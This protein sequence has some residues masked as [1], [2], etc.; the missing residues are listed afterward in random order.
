M[1]NIG[2][3]A[4]HYREPYIGMPIAL[5][6]CDCMPDNTIDTTPTPGRPGT[7]PGMM[8]GTRPGTTPGGGQMDCLS[9][10]PIAMAYVPMQ[11]WE[12]PY[13]PAE[14]LENGTIFPSLNLPFLGGSR[15]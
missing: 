10:L 13:E 2:R 12:T 1:N 5:D 7:N 4:A 3:N 9:T 6:D 11:R 8:P 15:R 14:G